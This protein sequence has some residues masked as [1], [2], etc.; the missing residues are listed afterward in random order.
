MFSASSLL[1]RAL[2]L[3]AAASGAMGVAFAAASGPLAALTALPQPLLL[4][5]GVF[6][7]GYALFLLAL[8]RAQRPAPALVWLVVVG[9]AGWAAAS[10]ILLF[11]GLVAPN[12]IGVA[13]VVAQAAAVALFAELQFMGQRR[14]PALA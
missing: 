2:Q 1:P 8:A 5:V 3:D 11:S 4:Y 7:I 12:A 14:M 13:V 10:L 9:N 6:C